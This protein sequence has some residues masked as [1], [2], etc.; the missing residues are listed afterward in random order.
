MKCLDMLVAFS[1]FPRFET[2]QARG[3]RRLFPLPHFPKTLSLPQ[4][5]SSMQQDVCVIKGMN[6]DINTLVMQGH[7]QLIQ[8]CALAPLTYRVNS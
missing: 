6:C 3:T 8:I 5:L 7:R 4:V 2:P 1:H